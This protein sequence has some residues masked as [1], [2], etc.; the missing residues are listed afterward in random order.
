M[1]A[2]FEALTAG[3]ALEDLDAPSH[4]TR[5][6]N[7]ELLFHRWFGQRITRVFMPLVGGF[8]RLPPSVSRRYAQLLTTTTRPYEWVNDAGSVSGARVGGL[9]RA[10][11]W[12][13]HDTAALP[14]WAD[15]ARDEGLDRGISVP[16][17]PVL[18]AAGPP[19]G[20]SCLTRPAHRRSLGQEVVQTVE[21]C[22]EGALELL[23]GV[24]LG[25]E[26]RRAQDRGVVL[27]GDVAPRGPDRGATLVERFLDG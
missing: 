24:V 15:A 17:R 18:S 26:G 20:R 9:V 2:D 7:R 5:W 3:A 21:Q 1:S 27:D 16:M 10:R 14:R 11:R 23:V 22:L 13:T 8:W 12:M 4:G 6:T 19:V 25:Q